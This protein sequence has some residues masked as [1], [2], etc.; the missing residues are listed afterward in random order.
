MQRYLCL[1]VFHE[2]RGWFRHIP[3]SARQFVIPKPFQRY[4][5]MFKREIPTY[6][7]LTKSL[8]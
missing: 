4:V 3:A 7:N 6:P 8:F 1:K 2:T 5:D